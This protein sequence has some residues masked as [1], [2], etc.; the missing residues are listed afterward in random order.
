LTEALSRW[1]VRLMLLFP[2]V[3]WVQAHGGSFT[4]PCTYGGRGT[5]LSSLHAIYLESSG[6]NAA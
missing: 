5:G 1:V 6:A 4:P 3:E 2:E